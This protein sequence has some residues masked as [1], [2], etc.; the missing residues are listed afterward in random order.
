MGGRQ[1]EIL[2]GGNQLLST[3]LASRREETVCANG[4]G[5]EVFGSPTQQRA[6]RQETIFR[7]LLFFFAKEMRYDPPR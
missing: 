7:Q 6:D 4:Y 1:Q 2:S 3:M 5:E